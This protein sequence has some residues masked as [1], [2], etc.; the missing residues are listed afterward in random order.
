MERDR[1]IHGLQDVKLVQ[2]V[3][4]IKPLDP[5]LSR[6]DRMM[7]ESDHEIELWQEF[8]KKK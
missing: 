7:K 2:N 5:N 4:T 3:Q 1:K 6:F 8:I